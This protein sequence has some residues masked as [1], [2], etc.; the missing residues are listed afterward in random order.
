MGNH[1]WVA[2][3]TGYNTA[4]A[5][6]GGHPP[7]S[8]AA[9]ARYVPRL[10]LDN[11]GAGIS[12]SYLYELLDEGTSVANQEQSFGLV[13]NDGSTKPAFVAVQNLIAILSDPGAAFATPPISIRI[14]GDTT[15]VTQFA[16]AKRDGRQYLV[17]YQDASSFNLNT[18]TLINVAAKQ[19][20]LQ[21]STAML[22]GV[23][24]PLASASAQ[25]S[26]RASSI[27]VA[28]SDS[29]LVIEISR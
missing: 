2:T 27:T 26:Q 6:Q 1:P 28:V 13:R 5:A 24:D 3:E 11:F 20:T 23:Y 16:F 21:F 4:V 25:S 15:G 19:V 22:V 12:R 10:L 18:R 7:V 9:M 17:L 29:P 8:E 14:S